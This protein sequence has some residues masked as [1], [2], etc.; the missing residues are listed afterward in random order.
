MIK[1]MCVVSSIAAVVL[2][3]GCNSVEPY[4][5]GGKGVSRCEMAM[6]TDDQ[7]RRD[8]SLCLTQS[9]GWYHGN[10]DSEDAVIIGVNGTF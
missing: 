1:K 4:V 5:K 6:N 3:A 7:L 2:V 10:G 8:Y 9:S